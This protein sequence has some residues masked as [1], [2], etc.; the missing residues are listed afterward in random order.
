VQ[1]LYLLY[2][3]DNFANKGN[4][5]F[6]TEGHLFPVTAAVQKAKSEREEGLSAVPRC[7]PMSE[8]SRRNN[9]FHH[10]HNQPQPLLDIR[11][12]TYVYAD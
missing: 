1:Y 8:H 9:F 3:E 7:P 6:N 11:P 5:V 10:L 12:K 2:D 4:Y